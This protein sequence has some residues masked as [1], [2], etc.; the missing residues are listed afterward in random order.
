[1]VRIT[2]LQFV[3]IGLSD[4]VHKIYITITNLTNEKIKKLNF[5][6]DSILVNIECDRKLPLNKITYFDDI[7]LRFGRVNEVIY[8]E[9]NVII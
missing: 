9:K 5:L 3:S 1:M 6:I 2:F 4:L 8:R 7:I